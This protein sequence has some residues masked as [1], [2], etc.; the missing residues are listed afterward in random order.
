MYF[1][2]DYNGPELYQPG[3]N[4]DV[5]ILGQ[6]PTID[7]TTRFSTAL[8]LGTSKSSPGRESPRL[9]NYLLNKVLIPLS[10]NKPRIMVTN[11]VN[12]YYCDV[13][14]SKIAPI[15]HEL[16]I[17]I[18]KEKGIAIEEYPDQTNGAI[19]HALNFELVTRRD[20]EGL[21]N[22]P[23]IK[24]LITLG[25]PLVVSEDTREPIY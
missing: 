24:H 22:T 25:E 21:L 15:Y 7:R 5:M 19:L 8:G 3:D 14:N 9:K 20:F 17:A 23:S 16:I 6:D 4:P 13:P 18:A 11:L 12:L 1:I 2:R 10:I